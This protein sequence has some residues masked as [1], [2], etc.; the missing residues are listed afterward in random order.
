MLPWLAH[1]HVSPY[2]ELAKKLA[3]QNFTILFCSTP[4]NLKP[5]REMSSFHETFPSIEL[6]DLQ[7]PDFPELPPHYHTTKDLPPH[8]MPLLKTAFDATGPS[9]NKLL[10]ACK[11]ELVIYDLLQPWVPL[12]AHEEGIPAILFLPCGAAASSF[13]AHWGISSGSMYPFPALTFPEGEHQKIIEFL[14]YPSNGMTDMSRFLNCIERSSCI[15]MIKSSREIESKYIDYLSDLT[16]KRIAPVGPLIQEQSDEDDE[17]RTMIINW[18]KKREPSSVV[19]VS[20]GSEYFPSEEEIH[21]IAGGLELSGVGFIWVVR[22]HGGDRRG[23]VKEALPTGFFEKVQDRGLVVEK[24]APQARILSDPS[25]GGFVSHCGW[26][27][28]LEAMVFGIPLVAVPMQL[29]QPLNARLATEVGVAMEVKRDG[30]GKLRAKEIARVVRE[31]VE[32]EGGKAVRQ[33]AKGLAKKMKEREDSEINEA[34]KMIEELLS[35]ELK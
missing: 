17:Q 33:R 13:F 18:L 3:C 22:F 34:V 19:F 23:S 12:T 28:T 30:E 5:I 35:T 26:S 16:G 25:V 1:S 2:L 29:D 21:E 11:P 31:V 14:G 32:G 27:S 10:K 8:L 15:I 9:L 6:T 4:I 20:F 24:W 7:L